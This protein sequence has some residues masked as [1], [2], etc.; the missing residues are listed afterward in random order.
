L[1]K[2]TRFPRVRLNR[3]RRFPNVTKVKPDPQTDQ[4]AI[5]YDREGLG[6]D[7]LDTRE[8]L[9]KFIVR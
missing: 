2:P 3:V 9:S 4:I 6:L 8:I 7:I 5:V 1:I